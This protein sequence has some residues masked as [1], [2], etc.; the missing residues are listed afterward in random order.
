MVW[1][2]QCLL[3]VRDILALV[4]KMN[5]MGTILIT[6]GIG[7]VIMGDIMV[8]PIIW[9][10]FISYHHF[11]GKIQTQNTLIKIQSGKNKIQQM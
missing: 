1:Y 9:I 8:A 3:K 5:I 6:M 7:E 4:E 2:H 11:K 10:H